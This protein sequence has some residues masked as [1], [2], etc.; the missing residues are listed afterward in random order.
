MEQRLVAHHRAE[1][2]HAPHVVNAVH[3]ESSV[4]EASWSATSAFEPLLHGEEPM[5]FGYVEHAEG[6]TGDLVRA[7]GFEIVV[8]G[9]RFPARASLSSMYDPNNER[10]RM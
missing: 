1:A 5:G 3:H 4:G 7:G 6:V 8:A 2:L 10:V 9:E